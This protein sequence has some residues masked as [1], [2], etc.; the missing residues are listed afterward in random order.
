MRAAVWVGMVAVLTAGGT[1]AG[2]D[3]KPDILAKLEGHRGGIPSLAFSPNPNPK[4]ALFATGA[5]NGVIRLWDAHTGK[6]IGIL[7]SQKHN[8]ARINHVGFSANG[9]LLSS[10][11]KNSLVVW[12][13]RPPPPPIPDPKTIDPKD[14]KKGIGEPKVVP[15][16]PP[17]YGWFLKPEALIPVIFEDTLGTD[18]VKI[19]TVT[20]DGK[21]VYLSS[22]E[23]ARITVN[24]N[25]LASHFGADTGDELRS[26]FTP[27]AVAAIPDF[28]SGLVA[29]YGS[30]KEGGKTDPVVAL[31][32]LGDGKVVG[33]GAVR[34]PIAGRPV[35]INFAPD[36]KLLVASNGEDLMYWKVPGSQVVT[37]DPKFLANSPAFVAAAGPNNRVAFASP[38]EE[39]KKV[40]VTIVDLA[41]TQ[42]KVVAVYATDIER[43]SALAFSRDGSTLA[44]AD[45][46]E[47]VVQLWGMDKK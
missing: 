23:G 28:E 43:V 41:A 33:R 40:K 37:G 8:G 42:P 22:T 27:I 36:G 34:T 24:S 26:A 32:G 30:S 19:G 7:D 12:N 5:G 16:P 4:V 21:R 18:A 17:D 39:G 2:Q 10:S 14:P 46:I 20:G 44:V 11:S 47:G 35:S 1:A 9:F 25:V 13:F 45:D 31:V 29:M 15:P 3:K 6:Y 38:P